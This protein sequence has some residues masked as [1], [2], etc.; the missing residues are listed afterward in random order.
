MRNRFYFLN[1]THPMVGLP[2]M[3]SLQRVVVRTQVFGQP[4]PANG[5]VEHP[6][7]CRSM[8]GAAV[9]AEPDNAT[10]EL[11]ITTRTQ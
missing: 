4:V 11:V 8:D 3:E 1:F 9:D 2:L 7:Q 5:V 10:G 6:A